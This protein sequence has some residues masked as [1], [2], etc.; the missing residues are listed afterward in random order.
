MRPE[1]IGKSCRFTI[2]ASALF[3]VT[4]ASAVY[5]RPSLWLLALIATAGVANFLSTWR[6][7]RRLE[8]A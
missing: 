7:V 2:A 1:P 3:A 4:S 6:L 5:A 8:V